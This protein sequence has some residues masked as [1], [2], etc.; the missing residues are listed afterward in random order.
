MASG[1]DTGVYL[2]FIR[3]YTI[4]MHLRMA[5]KLVAY[6][7]SKSVKLLHSVTLNRIH[8]HSI[9]LPRVGLF[10]GKRVSG[11]GG[12]RERRR[13]RRE[14]ERDRERERRRERGRDRERE[15]ERQRE[16]DHTLHLHICK[17]K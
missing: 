1:E 10:V 14:R 7:T 4:K 12:Q 9:T 13:E 15:R 16:I 17:K 5:P 3:S 8:C 11:G 6:K 2:S